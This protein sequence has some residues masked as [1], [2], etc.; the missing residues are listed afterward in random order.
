LKFYPSYLSRILWVDPNHG[1]SGSEVE[2][3]VWKYLRPNDIFVDIGANIGTVTLEASKK[4]G[5]NGKVFSFEANP[6]IFQFLKG[7]VN[8]NNCT[9]IELHN[10][11]LG[12]KT[13]Q[14]NF[15]DI[16][17]DE[18][19]SI[20]NNS[21]GIIVQMK[22]LD[23]IIPLD[24]KIELLKIDVLG[25]EKFVFLGAKKT[26]ENIECVHFPAIEKFYENYGYDFRDVFKILKSYNFSIYTMSKNGLSLLNDNFQP[27]I[28]DYL[29]IKNIK[30]FTERMSSF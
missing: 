7:N 17:S 13:S 15:S 2:N 11:A 4:I 1:H 30:K 18:S 6:K 23:E 24:L 3:F 21:N 8:L 29:A 9:N 20:Q 28:G 12:E 26:L 10:L 19:N 14:I 27:K 25:Y 5:D 22:T 16:D